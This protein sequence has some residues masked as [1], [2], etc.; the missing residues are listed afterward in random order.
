[1]LLTQA[2]LFWGLTHDFVE[3]VMADASKETTSEGDILFLKGENADYFYTLIKGR[4]KLSIGENDRMVFVVSHAGESFG[5]SS[6]VDRNEYSASAECV[7]TTTVVKINRER[8][9]AICSKFPQDGYIFM[10][11]VAGMLGRRLLKSYGAS[12]SLQHAAEATSHGT[13]QIVELVAPE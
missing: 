8:L 13:D 6:L 3:Q 1:M 5:W 9:E 2:E 4:V 10:K 7:D 12:L 11:R